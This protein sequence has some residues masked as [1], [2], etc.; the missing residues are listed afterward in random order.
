MLLSN[1]LLDVIKLPFC[2]LMDL[3]ELP[4]KFSVSA[5]ASAATS[6][7]ASPSCRR[8]YVLPELDG[9]ITRHLSWASVGTSPYVKAIGKVFEANKI[10]WKLEKITQGPTLTQIQVSLDDF[11]MYDKAV[12]IEGQFQAAINIAGVRVTQ[13]G[14]VISI[15]IPC[16]IDDLRVGD[17]L[18]DEKYKEG[19]GLTVA[20]GRGIDGKN[21]LSYFIRNR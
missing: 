5:A 3:I 14:A 6:P 20:I 19:D 11:R 12:K 2:F 16:Y 4:F 7:T 1:I 8:P 10:S 18:H 13:N 17:I 9:N 15:E 21:V